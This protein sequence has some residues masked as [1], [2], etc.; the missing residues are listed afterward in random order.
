MVL[1]M[2]GQVG[3]DLCE[4]QESEPRC[5]VGYDV[6]LRKMIGQVFAIRVQQDTANRSGSGMY[7]FLL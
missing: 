3:L 2:G 7:S 6:R 5:I 1:L 4:Q